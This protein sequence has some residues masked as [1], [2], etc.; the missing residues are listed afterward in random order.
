LPYPITTRRV[1]ASVPER[2]NLDARLNFPVQ[3]KTRKR[4]FRP[5]PL[6]LCLVLA[7]GCGTTSAD[8]DH[9]RRAT[10]ALYSA[11]ARHDGRT[12]CAQ[13]S[14][15]LRAEL[16]NDEG[17]RCAKAV[18]SLDLRG[19]MTD[20]VKV[21]ANEA[22][23][24]LAGGDTVFLSATREGWRVDALGCR[25]HGKGPYDCEATS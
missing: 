22:L 7:A 10:Q 2:W 6:A 13:M 12:A 9:A 5:L 11:A 21:Y 3:V 24:R 23:V 25:P 1:R 18:L 8:R 16:V 14:P 20:Q 4:M 15:S 19:R 17:E